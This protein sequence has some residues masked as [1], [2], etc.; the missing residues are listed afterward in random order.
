MEI[1][2]TKGTSGFGEFQC[3]FPGHSSVIIEN[4]YELQREVQDKGTSTSN[5]SSSH[6]QN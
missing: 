4:V 5:S 2:I 1:N 3:K 6:Q